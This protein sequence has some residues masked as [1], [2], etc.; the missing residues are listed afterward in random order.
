MPK[1]R[2]IISISSLAVIIL[3]IFTF[4]INIKTLSKNPLFKSLKVA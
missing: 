3:K 2:T 1:T 4:I